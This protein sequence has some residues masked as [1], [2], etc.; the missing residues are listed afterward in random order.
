MAAVRYAESIHKPLIFHM[1]GTR[2]EQDGANV[3]KNI[4][5]LMKA[6]DQTLILHPWMDHHRFLEMIGN[7]D[8]VLQVSLSETFCIVAA[9]AVNA[10]VSLIGSDQIPWLPEVSRAKPDSMASIAQ[11]MGRETVMANHAALADYVYRAVED[12]NR[13]IG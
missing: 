11:A 2:I 8:V 3:L 6:T 1:N 12:W 4:Q 13:W 5:A 10:C 7:M 9:D